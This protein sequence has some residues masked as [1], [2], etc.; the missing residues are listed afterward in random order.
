MVYSSYGKELKE[1]GVSQSAVVRVP[2][3]VLRS[4][5]NQAESQL[6]LLHK[7]F[8]L[9]VYSFMGLYMVHCAGNALAPGPPRQR[10]QARFD[11]FLNFGFQYTLIRNNRSKILG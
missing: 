9:Y 4:N 5:T 1:C 11:P 2:L 10:R 3:V 7:K 6:L 8:E